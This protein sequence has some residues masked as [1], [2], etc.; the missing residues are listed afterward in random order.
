MRECVWYCLAGLR[1]EKGRCGD[2]SKRDESAKVVMSIV[3]LGIITNFANIVFGTF[4]LSIHFFHSSPSIPISQAQ[5]RGAKIIAF[6]LDSSHAL[7][8]QLA[9]SPLVSELLPLTRRP[10]FSSLNP[11]SPNLSRSHFFNLPS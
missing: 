6:Q 7:I 11:L 2:I 3:G 1:N 8:N 9:N 10:V 5:S 4:F